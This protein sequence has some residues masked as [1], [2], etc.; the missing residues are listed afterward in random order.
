MIEIDVSGLDVVQRAIRQAADQVPFALSKALN[1]TA[2]KVQAEERAEIVRA[3]DKP[4]PWTKRQV[5]VKK[6]T[7]QTLTAIIA[8]DAN[9]STQ[10][11]SRARNIFGAQA[12][13][14]GQR[15]NKGIE[16]KLSGLGWMPMGWIIVP[17]RDT[18]LDQYGNVRKSVWTTILNEARP[19]AGGTHFV[20]TPSVART[21]HLAPGI[22]KRTNRGK[23]I[24]PVI[25]FEPRARYGARLQWDVVARRT[26]DAT[27][28]PEF[29]RAFADALRTRR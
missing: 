9:A 5:F 8:P 20:A 17:A 23:R 16:K 12:Y 14:T 25:L 18:P 19:G 24:K 13:G 2:F 4:T 3:F 26:I 28:A 21:R 22:Y 10:Q 29:E 1:A 7:K 15:R 11:S 6:A 27:F